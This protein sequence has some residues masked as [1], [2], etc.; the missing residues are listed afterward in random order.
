MVK[1]A[2]VMIVD[3]DRDLAESLA[4]LIEM[5]GH[6]VAIASNGKEALERA[7][8]QAFDVTFMDVRMPVMNGVDSF[9]EIR[10]L[11]PD[12][13]VVMMTGFKEPIVAKALEGGAM[14]LLHKPFQL[15]DLLTKLTDVTKPVIL[16]VD[17]DADFADGLGEL[18]QAEGY[19][20]A[21]A[22]TGAAAL[23]RVQSG[24]VGV[25][26]LDLR[27]P[28]MDGI[29]VY[30]RLKAQGNPPPTIIISGDPAMNAETIAALR[31]MQVK[32]C[33]AKPVDPA[34]L[35]ATIASLVA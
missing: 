12:A 26:I 5:H 31:E 7:R 1:Q 3:D 10:K 14:G 30:K 15:K 29:E 4:E 27:L 21:I 20:T 28:V 16:L 25:L 19:Q 17:D 18:L 8:E 2:N 22:G 11:R 34:A 35:L 33:L 32:D 6:K 23:T 9:L 13:K 24:G